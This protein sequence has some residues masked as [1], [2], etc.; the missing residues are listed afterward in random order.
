MINILQNLPKVS[1]RTAPALHLGASQ[2]TILGIRIY[3][4]Q[5]LNSGQIV[6]NRDAQ[7]APVHAPILWLEYFA[8]A[9]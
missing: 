6:R 4:R 8:T 9:E 1:G 7:I 3:D 5:P 2:A